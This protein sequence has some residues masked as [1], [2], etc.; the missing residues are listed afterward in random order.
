MT[1]LPLASP[2]CLMSGRAWMQENLFQ[3]DTVPSGKL[4]H[5]GE[6]CHS[7]LWNRKNHNFHSSVKILLKA[8][9]AMLDTWQSAVWRLEWCNG[10]WKTTATTTSCFLRD[11]LFRKEHLS[12]FQ[13]A[14]LKQHLELP[15]SLW[16]KSQD[17][18][19]K[20]FL[21]FLPPGRQ[22]SHSKTMRVSAQ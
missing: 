14:F 6:L 22:S 9:I 17:W 15:K 2:K 7:L 5:G 19:W 18:N 10:A 4:G 16:I 21:T 8:E 3:D 20:H 12:V 1:P 11:F 13:T